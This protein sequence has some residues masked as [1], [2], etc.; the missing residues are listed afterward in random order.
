MNDQFL[1]VYLN[2]ICIVRLKISLKLKPVIN[3][4]NMN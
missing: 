3:S 4:K 2:P 1:K